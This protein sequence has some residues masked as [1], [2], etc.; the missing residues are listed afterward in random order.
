MDRILQLRRYTEHGTDCEKFRISSLTYWPV[1]GLDTGKRNLR[2]PIL[3]R[4]VIFLFQHSWK[5]LFS[6]A[7]KDRHNYCN[8]LLHMGCLA[9][10]NFKKP[11]LNC[12]SRRRDAI[13]AIN[14]I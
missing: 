7:D 13:I 4:M 10:L 2:L 3:P 9:V 11:S 12:G 1:N 8:F 6:F 5:S 14:V